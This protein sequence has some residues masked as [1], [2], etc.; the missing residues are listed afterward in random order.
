MQRGRIEVN[1]KDAFDIALGIGEIYMGNLKFFIAICTLFGGWV[2]TTG[3][4]AEGFDKLL[5]LLSFLGP[6]C[7]M[8]AGQLGLAKRADAAM[9]LSQRLL[10]EESDFKGDLIKQPQV[11]PLFSINKT[12]FA[13][14]G[15]IVGMGAAI[16]AISLLIVLYEPTLANQD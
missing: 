14:N 4:T 9:E 5:L 15:T 12:V 16:T 1:S 2:V 8:L 3:I 10:A 11:A 6:T 7:A 13:K